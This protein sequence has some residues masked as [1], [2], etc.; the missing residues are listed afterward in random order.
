MTEHEKSAVF[1]YVFYEVY[2]QAQIIFEIFVSF[3]EEKGGYAGER[4]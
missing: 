4:L 1:V 2:R 3:Y